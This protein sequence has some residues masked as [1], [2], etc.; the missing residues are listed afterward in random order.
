MSLRVASDFANDRFKSAGWA[1]PALHSSHGAS[2]VGGQPPVD[3]GHDN[4]HDMTRK[5]QHLNR[6]D[7]APTEEHESPQT[8]TENDADLSKDPSSLVKIFSSIWPTLTWRDRL[9]LLIGFLTAFI[10]AVATPAFA[11]FFAKL[12]AVFYEAEN[13]A[14]DARKWALSLLGIAIIDGIACFGTHYA[15]EHIGQAWVSFLRVEA[16]KRILSQPRS[17]FER[18]F[19]SP[20]HLSECLDRNAEEMR[21][22]VGRF[23]ST[24]FTI[25]CMLGISIIWAF[26]VSWKLTLVALACAPVMFI[27]TRIFHWVSSKWEEKCN[28]ASDTASNVFTETFLNIKTVRSLTLENHFQVKHDQSAARAYMV[29]SRRAFYSGVLFGMTDAVTYFII[30]LIFY[31]GTVIISSG[32]LTVA[33]VIQVIN[34]LLFGIANAASM[35][36][37]IPQIS[38]SRATATQM[39]RLANLPLRAS[40]EAVGDR[41]VTNLFPIQLDNLSFTYPSK[42][43]VKTLK[44]IS[45][46]IFSGTCTAIVGQSG[47]GKST[48]ASILLGLYPPDHPTPSYSPPPLTFGGVSISDYKTTSL[49]AQMAIVPQSPHIFPGSIFSNIVYGLPENSPFNKLSCVMA[50]ARD[51]SI[52]DYIMSLPQGYNTKIGEGGQ[53][54]SGGQTQR[55]A[56]ARALVRRPKLLV[57]D[58]A[59][60][61]LDG[62][63][64]QAIMGTIMRMLGRDRFGGK[65]KARYDQ[66]GSGMAVVIISHS[67]EMMRIAETLVVFEDGM[68]VEKGGFEEL[69]RKRGAFARLLGELEVP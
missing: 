58:E 52:H 35:L 29:G 57:L 38:S 5:Q 18:E 59:T 61:A 49:R 31:Y 16:F 26:I 23:A 51:A 6:S 32:A 27:A 19:N 44:D 12:M 68:L 64:R 21:N 53:G 13:Q 41:R 69:R 67:V 47:S 2:D 60:S 42:E 33:S 25:L 9:I 4:R 40:H 7:T 28:D 8:E 39:L 11:F 24:A 22:L 34:L 43:S 65:G 66:Q 17:W 56:I 37:L 1:T 14:A 45:L 30:A 36:P 50:A 15:L 62:E 48:I 3:S 46:T 20:S 63:T 54:M 10:V 55:I